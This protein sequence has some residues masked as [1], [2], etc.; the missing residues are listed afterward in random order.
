MHILSRNLFQ[1]SFLSF[2]FKLSAPILF[3]IQKNSWILIRL[4]KGFDSKHCDTQQAYIYAHCTVNKKYRAFNINMQ[5][6]TD[7]L[8]ICFREKKYIVYNEPKESKKEIMRLLERQAI[9]ML[10]NSRFKPDLSW[11]SHLKD[12]NCYVFSFFASLDVQCRW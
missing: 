6:S 9:S 8:Y 10:S 3:S 7:L 5:I 2:H 11:S 4:K 1:Y 12:I